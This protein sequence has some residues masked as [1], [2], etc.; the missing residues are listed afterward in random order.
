MEVLLTEDSWD[1]STSVK[2]FCD[3]YTKH[4]FDFANFIQNASLGR[5]MK[6][7]FQLYRKYQ[8][9]IFLLIYKVKII[10]AVH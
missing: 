9:L 2:R 6:N 10:N 8:R 3:L 7:W 4:R 1:Y 5:S